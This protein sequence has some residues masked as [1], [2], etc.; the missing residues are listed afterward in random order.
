MKIIAYKLVSH[1]SDHLEKEVNALL[2]EGW[3]PLGAPG[4]APAPPHSDVNDTVYQAMVL[5]GDGKSPAAE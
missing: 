1:R 4:I 3:Q 5:Y 2:A